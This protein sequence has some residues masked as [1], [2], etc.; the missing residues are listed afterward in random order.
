MPH[1]AEIIKGIPLSSRLPEDK[2]IWTETQNGLFSGR[3]AYKLAV[4]LDHHGNRGQSSDCSQFRRFWRRMWSLPIPHKARHFGWRACR[5][6]LP[7]KSNLMKRKVLTEDA[8]EVCGEASETTGHVLWSCP[9]AQEAW[10]CSKL[11]MI[12]DNAVG[13]SFLDLMWQLLMVE[14]IGDE[15]AAKVLTIAWALWHNRNEMRNG[16]ARKSG[17]MVVHWARENL[18]EYAAAME[19]STQN[20]LVVGHNVLWTPPRAG[21]VKINVDGAT[22]A[23]QKNTGVGVLIRDD[24]GQL[25]AA[26]TR[27]FRASLDAVGI[28]AKAMET[29]LLFAKDRGFTDVTLEGDSL[30]LINALCAISSPPSSVASIVER[31][32]EICMDFRRIEFSHTQRQGNMSAHILAKHA[33]SIDNYIIWIEEEPCCI[34]Q[35]L[36][37][38][39]FSFSRM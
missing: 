23:K 8:C 34:E 17:Q 16:G 1:E 37:Y 7:T 13:T 11:V 31:L 5:E 20:E 18:A 35:A 28:E 36:I 15:S 38:D 6:S 39:V 4:K 10:T 25:R 2:L 33:V 32:Q 12:P 3:S 30:I 29:G 14:D 24:K 19:M 27:K 21:S 26:L 9:K 22:F